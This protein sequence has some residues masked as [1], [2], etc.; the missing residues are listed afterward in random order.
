MENSPRIL[1]QCHRGKKHLLYF[2]FLYQRVWI[3]EKNFKYAPF[4]VL[5]MSDPMAQFE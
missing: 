3:R 2:T 5:S 1:P 4:R